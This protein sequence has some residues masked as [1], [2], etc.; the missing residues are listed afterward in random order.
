MR[1]LAAEGRTITEEQTQGWLNEWSADGEVTLIGP[2]R[3]LHAAHT[4]QSPTLATGEHAP[5]LLRR[6]YQL[7]S[8]T[9]QK[10]MSTRDLAFAMKENVN[11]IGGELCSMLREVGVIR[12]QRGKISA[13]YGGTTGPRLPGYTADTL[14]KAIAVYNQRATAQ[15]PVNASKSSTSVRGQQIALPA[16]ADSS[17]SR[18]ARE[19]ALEIVEEAGVDG[20][21]HAALVRQLGQE[22]HTVVGAQVRSWLT[23]WTKERV[24]RQRSDRSYMRAGRPAVSRSSDDAPVPDLLRRAYD[25]A[26]THDQE[27]ISSR[28]LFNILEQQTPVFR[29][30]SDMA[31]QLV[32]LLTRVGVTRPNK[33]LIRISPDQPQVLGFTAATLRQAVMKYNAQFIAS[34]NQ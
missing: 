3:Y 17:L 21:N 9:P 32:R 12:P 33:G 5:L 27:M 15:Q 2:N 24:L 20:I 8:G 23:H 28:D 34:D 4:A 31:G 13:R 14:G 10:E 1:T 29:D 6:A 30:S 7:V 19:R 25:I 26:R 16:D 11:I 22:G 18:T